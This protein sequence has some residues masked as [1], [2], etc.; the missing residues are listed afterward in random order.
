MK[1]VLTILAI[2]TA[3]MSGCDQRTTTSSQAEQSYTVEPQTLSSTMYFSS[4]IEPLSMVNVASPEDGVVIEKHFIYGESVRQDQLL[5]KLDSDKL[6]KEYNTALTS[7]L[8][9]K[10]KLAMS[11]ANFEGSQDLY[12]LGIISR[13]NFEQDKSE[14]DNA[15]VSFLQ[16]LLTLK[17]TIKKGGQGH[18]KTL[19]NLSIDDIAAVAKALKIKYNFLDLTAASSG[20]ALVPPKSGSETDNKI[21]VGSEVKL[22]QV[23]VVIGDLSG[24]SAKINI[25]ET[26]IDKV[27]PGTQVTLTGSAFPN[28]ILLGSVKSV[29]SQASTEAGLGGGIPTFPATVVVEK[30]TPEQQAEIRV[31]MSTT[32][33][34]IIKRDKV[35][36]I[37]I[38]AVNQ[39]QQMNMVKVKRNGKVLTIPVTTGETNQTQVEITHGLMPGDVILYNENATANP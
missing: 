8:S 31:G 9:A 38:A 11:K 26:D 4:T 37:P 39:Q 24:V 28:E 19:E 22:G 25:E 33:K 1:S 2:C 13:N 23:L 14:F 36:M 16:A 30:L 15:N 35:M 12:K 18:E 20:V 27:K 17:D 32:V 34:L 29:A 3:L 10:D 6:E 7:F 21:E 5:A